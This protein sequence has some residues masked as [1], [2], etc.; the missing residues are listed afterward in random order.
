[1][2]EGREIGNKRAELA[3]EHKKLAAV[4]DKKVAEEEIRKKV[5]SMS[6][7]EKKAMTKILSGAGGIESKA[8]VGKPGA[9]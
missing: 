5:E 4:L 6:D 2:E 7:S 8:K 3:I 1:M 9:K